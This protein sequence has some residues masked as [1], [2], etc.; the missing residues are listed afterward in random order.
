MVLLLACGGSV[1]LYR[2]RNWQ[3]RGIRSGRSPADGSGWD[4]PRCPECV[5]V[6]SG[7]LAALQ[8]AE[9]LDEVVLRA[10]A[11]EIRGRFVR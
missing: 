10:P 3:G 11:E 5:D 2:Y 6:F 9:E 4:A 7:C 8:V 1:L